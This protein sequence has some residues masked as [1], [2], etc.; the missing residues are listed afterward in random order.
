MIV[1]KPCSGNIEFCIPR[2]SNHDTANQK[3]LAYFCRE[4]LSSETTAA[5]SEGLAE[6]LR[7][8]RLDALPQTVEHRSKDINQTQTQSADCLPR[9]RLLFQIWPASPVDQDADMNFSYGFTGEVLVKLPALYL[10]QL[11]KHS[12]N[13]NL[14]AM[15]PFTQVLGL[16]D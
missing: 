11:R 16:Q 4:A 8:P 13:W 15:L 10:S 3:P 6:E 14:W 2:M 7:R 5:C 9:I 1:A 12:C